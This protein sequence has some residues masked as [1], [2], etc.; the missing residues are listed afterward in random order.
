MAVDEERNA[1]VSTMSELEAQK[2]NDIILPFVSSR[3]LQSL[4]KNLSTLKE[5]VK[6]L[7][8]ESTQYQQLED[9]IT[10][11]TGNPCEKDAITAGHFT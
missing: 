7:K 6:N 3:E 11:L 2:Y 9:K 5:D 1:R 10:S 8:P 4:E